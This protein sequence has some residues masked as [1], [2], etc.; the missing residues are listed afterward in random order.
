MYPKLGYIPCHAIAQSICR[1]FKGQAKKVLLPMGTKPSVQDI[2]DRLESV[3]GNVAAGE[4]DARILH[5][6]TKQDEIVT[7]SVLSS[8]M[9]HL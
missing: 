2:L 4:C 6:H 7:A 5:C 9:E 1:S 3:F 8:T